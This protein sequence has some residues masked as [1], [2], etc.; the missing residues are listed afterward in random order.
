MKTKLQLLIGATVVTAL[1]FVGGHAVGQTDANFGQWQSDFLLGRS[2]MIR[3]RDYDSSQSA[4]QP[5]DALDAAEKRFVQAM[6]DAVG[7][8]LRTQYI[9]SDKASSR[10]RDDNTILAFQAMQNQRIIEQ[11]Q[12]ILATLNKIAAKPSK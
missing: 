11:N 1:A 6:Q 7:N 9:A 12:R 10:E 3:E 5:N 4:R 2:Q 8:R